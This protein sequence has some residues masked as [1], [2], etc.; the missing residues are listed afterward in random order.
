MLRT[1]DVPSFV[2][3]WYNGPLWSSLREHP[4]FP[5]LLR[6]RGVGVHRTSADLPLSSTASAV[7]MAAALSAMSTGR[8]VRTQLLVL[9]AYVS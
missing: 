5:A 1:R 4:Q 7:S 9:K 2:Q 8:M 6:R 3:H